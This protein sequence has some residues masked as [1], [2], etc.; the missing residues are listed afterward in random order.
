MKSK[1]WMFVIQ[2]RRRRKDKAYRQNKE[3]ARET[4]AGESQAVQHLHITIA[5]TT[6]LAKIEK[7]VRKLGEVTFLVTS[8]Q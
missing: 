6:S 7:T 2:Q 4:E 8:T 1:S 5:F 3:V